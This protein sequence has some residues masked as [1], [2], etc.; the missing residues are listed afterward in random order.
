MI[1]VEERNQERQGP[2]IRSCIW[3]HAHWSVSKKADLAKQGEEHAEAFAAYLDK[4]W[5]ALCSAKALLVVFYDPLWT[6]R[7]KHRMATRKQ[8]ELVRAF[9]K[10]L[11]RKIGESN[12]NA[13]PPFEGDLEERIRIV[14][15]ENL[16]PILTS[17]S[18]L[19]HERFR[20]FIIGGR[21]FGGSTKMSYDQAKIV[22]AVLRIR[23]I[24]TGIPV[25]RI[26]SDALLNDRTLG[27]DGAHLVAAI[28]HMVERYHELRRNPEVASFMFSGSYQP[29][30]GKAFGDYIDAYATR[31][32]PALLATRPILGSTGQVDEEVIAQGFVL[33][34]VRRYYGDGLTDGLV[35]IGAR[36]DISVISGALLCISDGAILDLPPFSPLQTFVMWIDDH[37]KFVMHRE[38]GHFRASAI[39]RRGHGKIASRVRLA[40]VFKNRRGSY[41]NLPSYVLGTYLPRLL[42][43]AVVDAVLQ[44]NW[45]AKVDWQPGKYEQGPLVRYLEGL[46]RGRTPDE[47]QVREAMWR[48]A[49]DRIGTIRAEWDQLHDG[50]PTFARIWCNGTVKQR[51]DD[52]DIPE[53]TPDEG[54]DWLG[55]GIVEPGSPVDLEGAALRDALRAPIEDDLERLFD[56][57]MLYCHWVLEWPRFASRV[58]AVERDALPCDPNWRP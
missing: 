13:Q 25:F 58:R 51:F 9:R 44:P 1:G 14:D 40:R 17:S 33:D 4:I 26:D 45:R 3:T 22:E 11:K 48:V 36:P 55:W 52:A 10:T 35:V 31:L 56:E 6:E 53:P 24:G 41:D 5:W 54:D 50:E 12:C 57:L 30:Q 42:W 37:L 7:F 2:E 8:S 19:D 20:R 21:R 32:F 46:L 47:V 16:A 38:M 43:G 34:V 49:L 18:L 23:Y 28:G 15:G 29:P 39:H 27:G